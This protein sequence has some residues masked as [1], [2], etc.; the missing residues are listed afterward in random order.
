MN[1]KALNKSLLKVFVVLVIIFQT[2]CAQPEPKKTSFEITRLS[3]QDSTSTDDKK[4]L[5][6]K[7]FFSI[8]LN[9][10]ELY[11]T[12]L[13]PKEIFVDI[14]RLN[15]KNITKEQNEELERNK[16]AIYNRLVQEFI[17]QFRDVYAMGMSKK[18]N[19]MNTIL[20]SIHIEHNADTSNSYSGIIYFN[21]YSNYYKMNFSGLNAYGKKLYLETLFVPYEDTKTKN[22]ILTAPFKD[23]YIKGCVEKINSDQRL[24]QRLEP[25][26]GSCIKCCCVEKYNSLLEQ[27]D[28]VEKIKKKEYDFGIVIKELKKNEPVIN[29]TQ[30]KS[31]K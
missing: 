5:I 11:K 4:N 24:I 10:E 1:T 14:Y 31:A 7:T 25:L 22:R 12:I 26:Y 23:E 3:K 30:T 28:A 21:D 27:S 6:T 15:V 19:W 20:D 2:A 8:Q 17:N 18:I 29:R 16:D 9:D 13:I